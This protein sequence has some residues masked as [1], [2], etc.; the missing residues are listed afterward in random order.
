MAAEAPTILRHA[1]T[2]LAGQLAVMAFSM[3]DTVVAGRYSSEALAALSVGSA[4]FVSVFVALTGV[5]Q[6]LLPVWAEMHGAGR[7]TEVGRAVRQA[8]LY[9]C[10]PAGVLGAAALLFPR[11]ILRWTDV[12]PALQGDVEHYLAVLALAL[13]ATLLFRLYAT[14]NQAL[15][16]PQLVTWLQ[17]GSVVV[18]VPLTV[19]FTFGGLGL[20]PMGVAGCAWA[21][22]ADQVAVLAMA[23]WLLRSQALYRPL[24][25]W[26]PM[27]RPDGPM[28]VRFLRLGVPAGLGIAVEVTSFTLMA[29]FIARQGTVALAAHQVAANVGAV[30]YM[31]P[32]SLAIA[33]SSRASYWLG[34]AQPRRA[35]QAAW[36]GLRLAMVAAVVLAAALAVLRSQVAGI[37]TGEAAVAAAAAAL[38]G[39]VALYHLA[40]AVQTVC[41]FLLRSWQVTV[42]TLVIYSVLLWGLGLGGGLAL[43][44]RGMARW[45]AWES[46]AAFWAAATLALMLAAA[47]FPWM[48]R[49]AM[50]RV[51]PP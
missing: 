23:V 35:R 10:V 12:P 22:V 18:K 32:L 41:V 38:L 43:A 28:L 19:W 34:A 1:G 48:L 49:R 11:P 2:V 45:P 44:Y 6:G 36:L 8:L 17:V 14:L 21:T 47:V 30:L 16:K 24:R 7:P 13:P 26:E 3:A 15:G 51:T 20:A 37:Y 29:L 27:E 25:L 9:I 5:V 46:P 50:R 40:D 31:V 42:S 39:W 4:V 33:S